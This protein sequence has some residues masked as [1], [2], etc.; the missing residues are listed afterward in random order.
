MSSKK[1]QIAEL[2][3]DLPTGR[4]STDTIR[5][6][7][8]HLP[9]TDQK[10]DNSQKGSNIDHDKEN[11]HEALGLNDQEVFDL[12]LKLRDSFPDEHAK[13]SIV[14]EKFYPLLN[15]KEKMFMV[16]KGVP[17]FQNFASRHIPEVFGVEGYEKLHDTKLT[18]E[19]KEKLASFL[20]VTNTL[21]KLK[22]LLG[23]KHGK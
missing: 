11:I 8:S 21:G 4:I 19:E 14:I 17:D 15:E 1:Q 7:M 2:L 10:G 5:W 6:V 20:S 12:A 13:K 3:Y 16:A 9:D 18:E 22:D 23:G